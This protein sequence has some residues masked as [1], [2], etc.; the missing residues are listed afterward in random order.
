MKPKGKV[1]LVGAGPGRKDLITV[2]GAELLKKA[3]CVICDKLANSDMLRYVKADAEII[4]VPKRIGPKSI[5]Q[6]Q[7]NNILVDR[8]KNKKIVVRLK[9]GDPGIFGRASEELNVLAGAGIDFE[10]VPGITS[11]I[12]AAEYAGIMLTDREFASQVV[13]VTGKEAAEKNETSIDWYWLAKFDGTIV[14][15]MGVE[16]LK[17]IAGKLIENG[18]PGSTP[19]AVIQNATYPTQK[20]AKAS[21]AD[22]AEK[23]AKEKI[24]PP[25][26]II[27]GQAVH[28]DIRLNW[29]TRRPLF[30]KNIVIT[31]DIKGNIELADKVFDRAANPIEFA[32]IKIKSQTESSEFLETLT[33]LNEFDWI[34]FTSQNGVSIFFDCLAR[35]GKDCRVFASAKIAAIGSRTAQQLKEFGIVAD[36]VPNVFTSD[37]LGKQLMEFT[38]LHSKKILLLR[39]ELADNELTEL[40]EKAGTEVH[41]QSVYA[42][43]P[44]KFVADDL[45]RQIKEN[46]VN[47]ITFASPSAVKSFFEQIEPELVNLNTVK[48]ASIGPITSKQLKNCDVKVDIESQVQ[49][50]DGLLNAIEETYQ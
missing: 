38:N 17:T 33:K 50:F 44:K 22:I 36:F 14:F 27:V 9:G 5:T 34:I 8:A 43:E 48:I 25:S 11:G 47:W 18:K 35:L 41:Q 24:A 20:I 15:Y 39:S 42:V 49:T 23:C 1:F 28:S 10:I 4:Y 37:Q 29:F 2:R 12:A 6:Q 19:V 7:I 21:L 16:N 32:A 40:L 13:F 26:I 3:D 45:K 31:R 46:I 30:G